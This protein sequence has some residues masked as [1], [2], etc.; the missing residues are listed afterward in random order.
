[1]K[2][3]TYKIDFAARLCR[4]MIDRGFVSSRS[5]HGACPK[6]LENCLSCAPML[7]IRYLTGYSLPSPPD[8]LKIAK[9]LKVNPGY[10]LFGEDSE[11]EFPHNHKLIKIDQETFKYCLGKLSSVIHKSTDKESA[12]EHCSKLI[13]ELSKMNID[14]EQFKSIFDLAIQH[15][16]FMD[17]KPQ[18]LS[19][20]NDKPKT[21]ASSQS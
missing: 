12:T 17:K 21:R 19:N 16:V 20:K 18:S 8:L 10:L 3:R 13:A 9:W 1:M 2:D 14:K 15:A 5:K 6:E 7:A 4:L 11:A